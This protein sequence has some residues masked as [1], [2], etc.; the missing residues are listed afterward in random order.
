M[1][2]DV[3]EYNKHKGTPDD[4]HFRKTT[5]EEAERCRKA[6]KL[7]ALSIPGAVIA[8]VVCIMFTGYAAVTMGDMLYIGIGLAFVA[9]AIGGLIFRIRDYK[10]SESYE[11]ADAK[12]VV[13]SSTN[14]RR[15]LSAWV[16][17]DEVYLRKIRFL[18]IT[19]LY[20]GTHVYIV[21]GDRGEGKKPH[22]F[23]IPAPLD[24]E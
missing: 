19:H 7:K 22:I 13:L 8:L 16:E 21:R 14:K 11:I 6:E 17:A 24:K 18:S 20:T 5:E 2:T 1:I 12:S 23:A 4:V 9:V 15:Y 10:T 3:I